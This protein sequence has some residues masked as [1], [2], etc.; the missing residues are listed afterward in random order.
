MSETETWLDMR[1]SVHVCAG[2]VAMQRA[3]VALLRGYSTV[4]VVGSSSDPAAAVNDLLCQ[5]ADVVLIEVDA[6]AE[7]VDFVSSLT[8]RDHGLQRGVVLVGETVAGQDLIRAALAAGAR[9]VV[10]ALL[11]ATD[12]LAAVLTVH[13]GHAWLSRSI[14]AVVMTPMSAERVHGHDAFAAAHDLTV[15]ECDV[16][17][18]VVTG[19]SN[20][21]ITRA[22]N[23]SERT[24]KHH[25][26]NVLRKSG[27]HDR[28]KLV[29]MALTVP[30]VNGER[31]PTAKLPSRPISERLDGPHRASIVDPPVPGGSPG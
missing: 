19:A 30:S 6:L 28:V 13:R 20:A 4:D 11:T 27:A 12:L 16:L 21:A 22:L 17:T 2:D 9:G 3:L 18:L 29:A 15:R 25:L 14:A 23:L 5:D 8:R 24:V 7:S 10:P 26:S 31:P 1:V